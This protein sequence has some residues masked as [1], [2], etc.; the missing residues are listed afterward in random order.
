M[1]STSSYFAVFFLTVS[2]FHPYLSSQIVVAI[3]CNL[4]LG[5]KTGTK[6]NFKYNEG[7]RVAVGRA[8]DS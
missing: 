5:N 6:I 7:Q 4:S 2:I 8:P 1:Y 3:N